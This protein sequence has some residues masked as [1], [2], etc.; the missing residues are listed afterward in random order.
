MSVASLILDCGTVWAR[1][2][3]GLPAPTPDKRAL[4]ETGFFRYSFALLQ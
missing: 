1:Q 4:S 3:L 2:G